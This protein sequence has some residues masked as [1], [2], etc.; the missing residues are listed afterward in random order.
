MQ[1]EST[2]KTLE[3]QQEDE[4]AQLNKELEELKLES[5]KQ[6]GRHSDALSQQQKEYE[7]RMAALRKKFEDEKAAINREIQEI[8]QSKRKTI[9]ELEAETKEWELKYNS[10]EARPEDLERIKKLEDLIRERTEAIEKVQSE[11]KHYQTELL[12][13]ETAYNKVFNN[14]PQVSVLNQL[15]RKAKRDQLMASLSSTTH[16][17]PLPDPPD[18]QRK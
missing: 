14:K 15:E 1:N 17:P 13:R 7:E 9:A 11:L 5:D 2:L 3:K 16:L 10:R 8:E 4:I 6:R 12:N 18:Y